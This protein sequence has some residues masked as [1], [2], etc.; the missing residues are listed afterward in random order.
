MQ[1]NNLLQ[2][3]QKIDKYFDRTFPQ[4]TGDYKILARLGKISEELGEL[5]SAI[6]GQLKLHRPEKQA[7]HQPSNVSEEWADLFNTVI[8][9]GIVLEI[10][11]PRS[12]N[13]RLSAIL[14]RLDIS[15]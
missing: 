2:K 15:E 5:N 10:D 3:Y 12:I 1:F 13:D 14:S 4:L 6:H 7:K 11:M 8:L 9:L